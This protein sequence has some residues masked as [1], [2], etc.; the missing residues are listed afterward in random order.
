M[1]T[2]VNVAER[3]L[4]TLRDWV[5]AG[6]P[7]RHQGEI[8]AALTGLDACLEQC[9]TAASEAQERK[10]TLRARAHRPEQEVAELK[11]GK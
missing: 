7:V 5:M 3:S 1:F 10:A 9:L 6:S 8:A 11:E 4:K 2:E